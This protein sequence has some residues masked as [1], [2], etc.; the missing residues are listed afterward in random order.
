MQAVLAGRQRVLGH[1]H[2]ATLHSAEG[3]KYAQS[4]LRAERPIIT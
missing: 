4:K 3:L 1:D 2:P